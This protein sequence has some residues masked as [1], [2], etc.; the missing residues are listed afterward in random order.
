M[1]RSLLLLGLC[2]ALPLAACSTNGSA[3]PD[4]VR[5]PALFVQTDTMHYEFKSTGDEIESSVSYTYRNRSTDTLYI[6]NCSGFIA[7]SFQ[8][9]NGT[10][11]TAFWSPET[12]L[13]LSAPIVIAPGATFSG[14]A[15]IFGSPPGQNRYPQL[16][17]GDLTGVYR[18][19]IPGVVLH[20][21]DR[22]QNHG[23]LVPLE[24]RSSN[25]FVMRGGF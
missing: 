4:V 9:K 8:K 12:N 18:L 14:K 11:W 16:P 21:S 3:I 17:L 19:V 2:T 5:D 24:Q 15:R 7:A 20:Y 22:N 1:L 23:T 10:T 6:V 13:C 25:E